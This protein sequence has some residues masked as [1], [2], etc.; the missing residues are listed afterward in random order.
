M[1]KAL[2]LSVLETPLDYGAIWCSM[3]QV[4]P[5]WAVLVVC[6]VIRRTLHWLVMGRLIPVTHNRQ[7]E[8]DNQ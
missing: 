7:Q 2:L 6:L 5:H 3:H 4:A 1:K 8:P